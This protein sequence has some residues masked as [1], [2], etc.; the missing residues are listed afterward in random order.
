MALNDF[1]TQNQKRLGLV[2]LDT[3]LISNLDVWSNISLIRQYHRNQSRDEAEKEVMGYLER[4]DLKK[5][6]YRRSPSLTNKE[7]F[8][9]MLLRA[10]M[11]SDAAIVIDRPFRIM[12][13]LED[14]SFVFE[15]IGVIEDIYRSSFIFDYSWF[16]E[17]YGV[18]DATERSI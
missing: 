3:P 1:A 15:C 17:R 12:P 16:R 13:E 5:I 14:G 4:Y 11:V 6:A 7:R 2:S 9:V 18:S 10:A 8:C